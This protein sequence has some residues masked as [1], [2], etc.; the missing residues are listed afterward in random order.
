MASIRSYPNG[1]G[2]TTGATL[3]TAKPLLTSGVIWYLGNSVT[4]ASDANAG[5]ERNAPL[6]TFL[7]AYTNAS[8]GDIID[9]L[10]GHSETISAHLAINKT[11]LSIIG[12]GSGSTV[13]RFTNNVAAATNCMWTVSADAIL[14]DTLTFPA[15]AVVARERIQILGGSGRGRFNNLTFYCG[16]NDGQR[17]VLLSSVGPDRFHGCSF[18]SVGPTAAAQGLEITAETGCELNDVTFDGGS[19]GWVANGAIFSGTGSTDLHITN[20]S[21]LNGSDV[22]LPTGTTGWINPATVTGD[23]NIVWT[24]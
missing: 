7:Q 22:T 16:A 20:L 10:A 1:A 17:S 8:A 19:F 12:E 23:S 4:G 3:A 15:S 13:P 9:V 11:G 14:M 2:G 18:I 21:L 5:T 6:L 24:P